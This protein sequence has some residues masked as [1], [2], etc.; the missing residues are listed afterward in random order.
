MANPE[1]TQR[2]LEAIG[3]TLSMDITEVTSRDSLGEANFKQCLDDINY[4]VSLIGALEGK[5]IQKLSAQAIRITTDSIIKYNNF[6][7]KL[8]NFRVTAQNSTEIHRTL[9]SEAKAQSNDLYDAIHTH[10]AY[11]TTQSDELT[12]LGQLARD[13][14]SDAVQEV[15]FTKSNIA[16]MQEEIREALA[17][18]RAVSS[19]SGVAVFSKDFSDAADQAQKAALAWL[20]LTGIFLAATF[21][22]VVVIVL[23]PSELSGR[24]GLT[25]ADVA[26][27][28]LPR[29]LLVTVLITPALWCARLFRAQMHLAVANRHRAHSLGTFEAFIAATSDEPT[30]NAVLLET[31]RSIFT[32]MAS[33]FLGGGSEGNSDDTRVYEV[34]RNI[35]GGGSSAG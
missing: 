19:T 15:E 24:T 23:Y 4:A 18:A 29:V 9:I 2:L 6:L 5:P 34:F 20:V 13:A 10:V 8:K 32:P 11:L 26:H 22:A 17:A 14:A 21:V 3:V 35:T 12:K 33:G 25:V 16:S 30:R 31:T 1:S 7:E 27:E 28:S